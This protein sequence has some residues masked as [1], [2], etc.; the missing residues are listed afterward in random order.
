MADESPGVIEPLR[1]RPS[2]LQRPPGVAA[3]DRRL[4]DLNPERDFLSTADIADLWGV[5]RQKVQYYAARRG[6]PKPVMLTGGVRV[7][8]REEIE[9]YLP[10]QQGSTRAER[11]ALVEAISRLVREHGDAGDYMTLGVEVAELWAS[12]LAEPEAAGS[13]GVRRDFS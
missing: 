13:I 9:T 6:F 1:P 7:W 4:R 10:E 8:L 5:T 3:R 12:R 2:D 11:D